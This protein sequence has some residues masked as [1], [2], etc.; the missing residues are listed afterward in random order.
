MRTVIFENQK[1]IFDF[2]LPDVTEHLRLYSEQ[3]VHE[4]SEILEKISA[5]PSSATKVS[6]D[7]FAFI[8]LDL[9]KAGKGHVYCRACKEMYDPGQLTSV[10]LGFGKSPFSVNLK[11]KGG[12]F[13]RLS[14]RKK[15]ICGR[16]GEG[17]VCP[18]GHELIRMIT[19][20][21]LFQILKKE[22][23]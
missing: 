22:R 12:V 14:D 21:G 2:E 5:S 4:A 11:E 19:W 8:V 6:S 3:G 10:S 9:I 20:T 16:G 23:R 18:Q 1:A 7:Y 17:Y 13:R 15:R